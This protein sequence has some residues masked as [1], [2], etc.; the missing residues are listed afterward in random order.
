MATGNPDSPSYTS[1]QLLQLKSRRWAWIMIAAL[2]PTLPCFVFIAQIWRGIVSLGTLP[3][4]FAALGLGLLLAVG[5][6]A[7][8]VSGLAS[9]F[10]RVEACFAEPHTERSSADKLTITIATFVSFVPA[11]A[12]LY[13]PVKAI[14]T[15]SIAFRGPGQLYSLATDPYGYWQ[16][17]TF[18]LMGAAS[19]AFLAARYWYSKRF[20]RR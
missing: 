8:I 9:L 20:R 13:V 12:A 16:A 1:R 2:I 14:L 11:I 17:V 19:L 10:L 6:V 4:M 18:W 3:F 15:G 5:P 7:V